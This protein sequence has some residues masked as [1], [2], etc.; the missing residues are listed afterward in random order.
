MT[1]QTTLR[2][3]AVLDERSTDDAVKLLQDYRNHYTG[4][5]FETLG[6]PWNAPATINTVT[7]ADL[8]ALN[9]LSVQGSARASIE[10]L[11]TGLAQEFT[12][13][14]KQIS[15]DLD[16]VD[17]TDADIGNDSPANRLWQLCRPDGTSRWGHFGP[18]TTS[19]LLA[20]KRPRLV[21]IYDSV[22]RDQYGLPDSRGL[23]SG[24]RAALQADDRRLHRHAEMLRRRA[25]LPDTVT[26]LRVIDIVVWMQGQTPDSQ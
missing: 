6:H 23:W 15:P 5:H 8:L 9:T 21:P 14:L 1:G 10:I 3:P 24:M 17:A 4:W 12:E 16:L 13:L 20:R 7:A 26:P 25:D 22:V 18:V 2:I 19:K 11:G